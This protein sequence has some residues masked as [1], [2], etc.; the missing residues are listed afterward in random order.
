MADQADERPF[1][2][3]AWWRVPEGLPE[4]DEPPG[5]PPSTLLLVHHVDDRTVAVYD[6]ARGSAAPRWRLAT[7]ALPADVRVAGRYLPLRSG[8]LAYY[9]AAP[10]EHPV[11]QHRRRRVVAGPRVT[12]RPRWLWALRR[13]TF[14]RDGS[15]FAH[16]HLVDAPRRWLGP[17]S[18]RLFD[19]TWTIDEDFDLVIAMARDLERTSPRLI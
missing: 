11:V 8:V 17:A 15:A 9:R 16:L 13:L 19:F 5:R 7:P 12:C 1:G 18:M 3:P 4:V 2:W 6:P 10:G 14:S